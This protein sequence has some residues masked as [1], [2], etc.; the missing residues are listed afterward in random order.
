MRGVAGSHP[1][2]AA[3]LPSILVAAAA[4]LATGAVALAATPSSPGPAGASAEPPPSQLP[5]P[6]GPLFAVR[7]L[8]PLDTP[9][10]Q[11]VGVDPPSELVGAWYTGD[12]SSVGYLDPNQGSYASGGSQGLM[13]AF[14]SDGAWQSGWLL[15]SQLYACRMQ[16]LVYRQGLITAS[17]PTLG[18]LRLATLTA[19][20]R[21]VDDCSADGNYQRELP[22]DS[23]DLYWSRTTDAY[24]DVLLLRGPDTT[25]SQFRPMDAG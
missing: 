6:T 11:G 13:Y 18:M 4:L 1:H 14:A 23:E 8:D 19:Q 5:V 9:S 17:D 21:S 24:G 12:V 25:W 2:R 10:G 3:A 22:H 16:V 15:T 20:I 7:S